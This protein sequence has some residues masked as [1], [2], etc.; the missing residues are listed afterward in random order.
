MKLKTLLLC[1]A[2]PTAVGLVS[3][4]ITGG[5]M[6]TFSSLNK[7]PLSPPALLFPIVWTVLYLAM[8]FASYLVLQSDGSPQEKRRALLPYGVQLI[9]NFFWSI[10]FFSFQAYFFS[11]VWLV[12]L[13]ALIIVCIR[14]FYPLSKAAAWLMVPY[15]L[16]VS[17]AGYLN[18]GISILN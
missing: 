7:P 10:W 18:L 15:L 2:I 9:F 13:W 12:V 3:A 6:A 1:L 11:F 14:R 17:F 16:W 5:A 8:G 4:L